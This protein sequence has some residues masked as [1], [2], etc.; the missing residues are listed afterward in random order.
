MKVR[1]ARVQVTLVAL[2]VQQLGEFGTSYEGERVSPLGE[3]RT[4]WRFYGRTFGLDGHGSLP[5]VHYPGSVALAGLR[6]WWTVKAL[7][8]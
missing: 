6:H 4:Q 5:P 8:L 2:S 3:A 1:G 7:G